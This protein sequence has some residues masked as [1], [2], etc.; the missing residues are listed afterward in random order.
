MPTW[1]SEQALGVIYCPVALWRAHL[2][3]SVFDEGFESFPNLSDEV[4]RRQKD[5]SAKAGDD[6]ML[7]GLC[8]M[9]VG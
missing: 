9:L 1:V 6:S 7:K 4:S 5:Q 2:Q 3:A 8:R